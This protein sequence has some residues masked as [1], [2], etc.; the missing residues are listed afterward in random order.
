M[1]KFTKKQVRDLVE[2][3]KLELERALNDVDVLRKDEFLETIFTVIKELE[4]IERSL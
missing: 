3:S 2:E 1:A 4:I